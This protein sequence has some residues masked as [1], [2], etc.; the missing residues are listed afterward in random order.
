VARVRVGALELEKNVFRPKK[1]PQTIW[2]TTDQMAKVLE[3][4][5]QLGVAPNVACSM[6]ISKAL[7]AAEV[8]Q[9]TPFSVVERTVE[10]PVEKTVEVEKFICPYCY[11][12]FK[13]LSDLRRHL[14]EGCR[15]RQGAA[16]AAMR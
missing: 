13:V 9:W 10:K 3:L 2:L 14:D 8:G 7:E 11:V 5:G 12:D 15:R 16:G 1:M 6:L 4:A